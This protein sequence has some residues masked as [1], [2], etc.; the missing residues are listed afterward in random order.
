VCRSPLAWSSEG[1]GALCFHI[2]VERK[3]CFICISQRSTVFCRQK[4]LREGSY[5]F[6][7][8]CRVGVIHGHGGNLMH[9]FF[10]YRAFAVKRQDSPYLKEAQNRLRSGA[11]RASAI[12]YQGALLLLLAPLLMGGCFDGKWWELFL[13]ETHSATFLQAEL[14]QAGEMLNLRW[15]S[16]LYGWIK[17]SR[18]MAGLREQ[19]GGEPGL[20]A[21]QCWYYS[22]PWQW[23]RDAVKGSDIQ[24]DVFLCAAELGWL[25]FNLKKYWLFLWINALLNFY[26]ER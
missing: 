20:V 18:E 21:S 2:F 25:S 23:G 13:A 19:T 14:D 1:E 6:P 12:L 15:W 11:K 4:F 22:M 10:L 7:F 3:R 17:A 9:I 8:I 26:K 24:S 5:L 16:H